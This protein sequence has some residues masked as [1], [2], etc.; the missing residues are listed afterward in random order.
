MVGEIT[1]YHDSTRLITTSRVVIGRCSY[2]L[3]LVA[4]VST[5]RRPANRA[6]AGALVAAGALLMLASFAFSR[7]TNL[8]ALVLGVCLAVS[9]LTIG[10]LSPPIFTVVLGMLTGDVDMLESSDYERASALA[11]AVERAVALRVDRQSA[12]RLVRARWLDS[13]PQSS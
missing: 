4:S 5:R 8:V 2:P 9:G 10:Y 7:D 11:K 6:I 3:Q 12:E 13:Q 1:I